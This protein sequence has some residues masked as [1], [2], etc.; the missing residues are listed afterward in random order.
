MDN[1][2]SNKLDDDDD[3]DDNTANAGNDQ[4]TFVLETRLKFSQGIV[5]VL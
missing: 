3:D 2:K 1:W 4:S 5:T